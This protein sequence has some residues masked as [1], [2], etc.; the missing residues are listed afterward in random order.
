[1]IAAPDKILACGYCGEQ[2][3]DTW[4]SCCGEVHFEEVLRCPECGGD[5]DTRRSDVAGLETYQ[6]CCTSCHYRSEPE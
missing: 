4:R 3:F 2:V 1:M 5:I 6:H